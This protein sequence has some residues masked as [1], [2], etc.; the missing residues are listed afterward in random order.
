M[1]DTPIATNINETPDVKVNIL[2]KFTLNPMLTANELPET[3]NLLFGKVIR[4]STRIN[5]GLN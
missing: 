3:I 1:P 2:S 5:I 4:L